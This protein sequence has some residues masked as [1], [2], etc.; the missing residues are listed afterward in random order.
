MGKIIFS[1]ML[2]SIGVF[3]GNITID[4]KQQVQQKCL[5]CHNQEQIP[6]ALIYRRYLKKYSTDEA[7]GIAIMKYLKNPKQENSI[8]PHP[9]FSK[10]PMKEVSVLNDESLKKNIQAFLHIFD[11]K[12]NLVLPE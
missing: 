2:F 12:K 7:M 9:F 11:L 4:D 10:F 6:N 5:Q 1:C 8:M 3:A